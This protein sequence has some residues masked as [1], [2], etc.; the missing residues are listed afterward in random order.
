MP[1]L[2][3]QFAVTV[4]VVVGAVVAVV[5]VVVLVVVV[6]D[7]FVVVVADKD[8]DVVVDL[9]QEASSMAATNKRLKPNQITLFFILLTPI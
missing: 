5:V 6:V 4:F 7:V 2:S 1:S 8:V 9:A 3:H